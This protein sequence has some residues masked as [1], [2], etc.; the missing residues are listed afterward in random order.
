MKEPVVFCFSGGKD[1]VM[2]L[3]QLQ[4]QDQFEISTL[5]TT[6]TKDYDRISMHAV[7]RELLEEQAGSLGLPLEAV[8]ITA[9]AANVEYEANMGKAWQRYFEQGIRKVVFGDIFLE[10]LKIYREKQLDQ[11]GLEC[12]F[13]I[14]K[15]DTTE[16]ANSFIDAGFRAVTTCVDPKVLDRSFVGR[17]FNRQF[18]ADLPAGA[19]PCGENGEFHSFVFDGPNFDN[20]IPIVVGEKVSRDS[21]FFCDLLLKEST[22]PQSTV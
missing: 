7:R 1:S 14:W 17:E 12:L 4:Q 16:L 3:H 5:V 18:L 22:C 19:D 20:E 9:G 21:F 10:D 15:R 8:Y 11:F 2:A 13:P 6:L